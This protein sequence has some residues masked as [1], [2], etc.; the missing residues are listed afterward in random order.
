MAAL[1]RHLRSERLLELLAGDA[2]GHLQS[3][4]GRLAHPQDNSSVEYND[5]EPTENFAC[6]IMQLFVLGL[7]TMNPDGSPLLVSGQSVRTYSSKNITTLFTLADPP[8]ITQVVV[9]GDMELTVFLVAAWKKVCMTGCVST[10][11]SVW[12]FTG[13]VLM[14]SD[15]VAG[16]AYWFSVCRSFN[17]CQHFLRVH[18][19]DGV[20][21]LN[22]TV[23][24]GFTIC[25]L[26]VCRWASAGEKRAQCSV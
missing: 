20:W 23:S 6:E 14:I 3:R 17:S 21:R 18:N 10:G 2:R 12:A 7:I 24:K 25:A 22:S 1:P 19:F 16:H 26:D 15:L 11:A 9:T 4:H 13:K 5:Q 8:Y